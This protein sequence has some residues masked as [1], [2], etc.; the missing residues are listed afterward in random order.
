MSVNR[1]K[2]LE[3]IAET[4]GVAINDLIAPDGYYT[5]NNAYFEICRRIAKKVG[6]F[7]GL[8]DITDELGLDG[9]NVEVDIERFIDDEAE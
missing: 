7:D 2:R 3:K 5:S 4:A 8:Y 6:N 9:S 1:D